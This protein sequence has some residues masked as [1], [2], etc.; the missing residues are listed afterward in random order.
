MPRSLSVAGAVS[1]VFVALA[2]SHSSSITQENLLSSIQSKLD[3]KLLHR[4]AELS[5]LRQLDQQLPV[6]VR[7]VSELSPD[8]ERL[9]ERLG[10]TIRSKSGTILSA[11]ISAV[12]I[13]DVAKLEFIMR[14]ELAKK[15]KPREDS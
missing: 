4:L 10:M 2:C 13:P 6:L 1:L 3:P 5:D 8:Q 9:L 12:S 14:I 15:L 7:T 11:T